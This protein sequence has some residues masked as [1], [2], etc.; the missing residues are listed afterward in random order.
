MGLWIPFTIFAAFM[1]SWRNAFQN[2]LSKEVSTAG[3]TLARFLYASPLAAMYLWGLYQVE[4]IALPTVTSKYIITIAL[5]S[6]SQII[7]TAL[8]VMLFRLRNY[9]IGVGLAK[10]EA[11]I[12]ATLGAFFFSAPLSGLAWTGVIIGAIA[13]W[14]MSNTGSITSLSPKTITLGLGSG[15]A[16]ALTTL[17]VREASLMLNLPFPYSAAWVLLSVIST[18]TILL[19]AWLLIKEPSTLKALWQRPKLTMAISLCSC[20]GSLGW[21]TA[22]SLETVAM[23]KTLGQIEVLFTLFISARWFKEKLSRRD[24][25]GLALIM[26]GAA[27]VMLA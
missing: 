2:K 10:S 3:V 7:A 13:V 16:F 24:L 26:L 11:V 9:A 1:Q 5:A 15:L 6:V 21:F 20:L 19:L 18:Q 12:A 25:S 27:C 8:M 22:M 4:P 17:W 23:V 14:L